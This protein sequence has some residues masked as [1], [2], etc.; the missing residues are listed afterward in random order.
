MIRRVIPC[1]AKSTHFLIQHSFS[2]ILSPISFLK[3]APVKVKTTQN[4]P[5][6]CVPSTGRVDIFGQK[7][8]GSNCDDAKMKARAVFV[9][10]GV[11]RGR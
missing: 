6:Y 4:G 11:A 3:T 9:S 1:I 5:L 10:G 7:D 8:G 2:H